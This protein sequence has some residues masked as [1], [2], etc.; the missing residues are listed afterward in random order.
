[1][2]IKIFETTS[3]LEEKS[4]EALLRSQIIVR[5][6]LTAAAGAGQQYGYGF[7]HYVTIVYDEVS[8]S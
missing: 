5:E 4:M 6:V 1:M 3:P 8:Q 2:K 7:K